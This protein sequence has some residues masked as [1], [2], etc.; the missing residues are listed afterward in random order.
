VRT[1]NKL[2]ECVYE[3]S[4]RH[5]LIPSSPDRV[6][7]VVDDL[8]ITGMHMTN[9]SAM[10]MGSKFH[11]QYLTANH[12]GVNSRYR[13]TGKMM[14]LKMDFTVEVTKWTK[15]ME[16]IWETIGNA[17]M[18]I[19]SWYQMRLVLSQADGKTNAELS[20]SYKR[21][22]NLLAR[23][24]AWLFAGWYCNWCLKKMLKDTKKQ[25]EETEHGTSSSHRVA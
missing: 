22:K 7:E 18:I 24:V 19:Y 9:S 5:I 23:F 14:G 4:K 13:W 21:P 1:L 16:K 12:S 2:V 15:G 11:L 10:M 6:F 20:I 17:R 8:G 25:L 3:D